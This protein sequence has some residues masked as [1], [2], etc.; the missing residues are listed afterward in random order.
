MSSLLIKNGHVIDPKNTV[1][2]VCDVYVIDGKI[3]KVAKGITE[4]ADETIDATGLTVTP[5]LVDLQVHFREPGRE[6]RETILTGSRAALKGGV[7]SAVAMPNTTPEA[8]NQSIIEF[9]I[10]RSKDVGLINIFPTGATT[11]GQD[12]SQLSEM[13]ELKNSGAVAVTDDG[14]DVQ[15]EG[16]FAMPWSMPRHMTC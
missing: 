2:E 15:D 10:N 5:G 12:G 16:S 4:T 14:F 9:I 3:T 8:D 6:D 11:K 13:K 1:D 7:T